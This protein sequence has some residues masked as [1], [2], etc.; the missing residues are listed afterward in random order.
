[1]ANG[2]HLVTLRLDTALIDDVGHAGVVGEVVLRL[3]APPGP[4]RG[5]SIVFFSGWPCPLSLLP[6]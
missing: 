6:A 5:V 1:M 3:R 2:S 4:C